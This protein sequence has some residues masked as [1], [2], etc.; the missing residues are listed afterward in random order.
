M[1]GRLVDGDKH[2]TVAALR[3]LLDRLE[4]DD[5]LW[6]NDLKNF[7]IHRRGTYV[8]FVEIGFE[9]VELFDEEVMPQ[10]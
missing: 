1:S 4:P 7:A 9:E 10:A 5:E 3:S 2:I 8:G 6:P